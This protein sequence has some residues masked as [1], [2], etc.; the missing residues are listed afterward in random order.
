[1]YTSQVLFL[2]AFAL[3]SYAQF[4]SSS[5][6]ALGGFSSTTAPPVAAQTT[7]N[8]FVD[9]DSD[10]QFVGSVV[11]ADSCETT[12]ALVCTR[13][14]YGSASYSTTCDPSQTVS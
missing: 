2:G 1:M 8:L 10:E 13:G 14:D 12:Y 9:A 7:V 3:G 4:S 11:S 5:S 6:G